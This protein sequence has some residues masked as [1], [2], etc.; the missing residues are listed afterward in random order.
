[1]EERCV[2][3][4]GVEERGVEDRDNCV[5]SCKVICLDR[6]YEGE[7]EIESKPKR[8]VEAKKDNQRK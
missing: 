7:R 4:R 2:E 8:R 5:K 3:E 6:Q 1:M